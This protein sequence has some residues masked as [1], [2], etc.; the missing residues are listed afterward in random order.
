MSQG[1]LSNSR[2][3]DQPSNEGNIFDR[4][5]SDA[6]PAWMMDVLVLGLDLGFNVANACATDMWSEYSV[7]VG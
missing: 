1:G 2:A 4:S 5:V 3:G 6:L 7:E